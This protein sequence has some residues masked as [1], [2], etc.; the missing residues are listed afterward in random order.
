MEHYLI[1]HIED[2]SIQC[3]CNHK[4][5]YSSFLSLNEQMEI[6]RQLPHLFSDYAFYY[7]NENGERKILLFCSLYDSIDEVLHELKPIT[8]LR[9]Y[10]KSEKFASS[11]THRD[12]LGALMSLGIERETIGDIIIHDKEAY[13]YVLS[14]IV[15]EIE[16]SLESIKSNRILVEKREDL[17][18]P[19]SPIYEERTY[20]VASNRLDSILSEVFHLSREQAKKE[21]LAGNVTMSNHIS[22]KSDTS[23]LE[24]EAVSFRGK[25]KLYYLGERGTSKK[26]KLIIEIKKPK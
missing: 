16:R 24:N 22:I 23:L 13:V 20:Q 2:L 1:A 17:F 10:P 15:I 11:I 5:T 8:L 6:R 18:C 7:G 3:E 19:Y 25:G 12:V 21:I 14:S 4:P 26:G 9:I